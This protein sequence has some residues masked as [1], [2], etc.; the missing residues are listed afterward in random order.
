MIDF[1]AAFQSLFIV[2]A[3]KRHLLLLPAS[4]AYAGFSFLPRKKCLSHSLKIEFLECCVRVFLLFLLLFFA[5]SLWLYPFD[6]PGTCFWPSEGLEGGQWFC[7]HRG[8]GCGN[9]WYME[10]VYKLC[11]FKAYLR[12]NPWNLLW[13]I[14][15]FLSYLG[16]NSLTM[17]DMS[18]K[19]AS[20]KYK[21]LHQGINLRSV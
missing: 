18:L 21:I 4:K 10:I 7:Q 12:T 3:V 17:W 8:M 14:S 5:T 15:L 11:K 9:K 19:C 20:V 16:R 6:S 13:E 2:T 1:H